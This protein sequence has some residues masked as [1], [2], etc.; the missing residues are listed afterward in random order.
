MFKFQTFFSFSRDLSASAPEAFQPV[1]F[2]AGDLDLAANQTWSPGLNVQTE[3]GIFNCFN[4]CFVRKA[5]LEC[6]TTATYLW[7]GTG[8]KINKQNPAVLVVI[9]LNFT[10]VWNVSIFICVWAGMRDKFSMQNPAMLVGIKL[11]FTAVSNIS[12]TGE[13]PRAWAWDRLG[14]WTIRGVGTTGRL[15][16]CQPARLE[17]EWVEFTSLFA[18]SPCMVHLF[19]FIVLKNCAFLHNTDTFEDVALVEFMSLV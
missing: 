15:G 10:A 6:S 2:S 1:T 9:K 13:L 4:S 16:C 3:V 18:F 11:N 19:T 7:R 14:V 8:D 5:V 17:P 12:P